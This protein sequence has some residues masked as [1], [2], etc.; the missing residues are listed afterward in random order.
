MAD[1]R[2]KRL[3]REAHAYLWAI[4]PGAASPA[5]RFVVLTPGRAGSQLVADLLNQHSRV[6]CLGELLSHMWVPTLRS[7]HI[8][9][10]GRMAMSGQ[11]VW[12]FRL[13]WL[14]LIEHQRLDAAGFLHER[15]QSGWRLIWARRR[16]L[17]HQALSYLIAEQRR[18]WYDREPVTDA[19]RRFTID[20]ARF[21]RTLARQA[22][23]RDKANAI[24]KHL[25]HEEVV[26]EDDLLLEARHQATADR[27]FA[28]LGVAP[29]AV[30]AR[31]VKTAPAELSAL[32]ANADELREALGGFDDVATF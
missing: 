26:Y 2:L 1:P 7:A 27:L 17:A 5:T 12:G 16:N 15:V 11:P 10:R 28:Y 20:P 14:H 8:Y 4:R 30:K 29:V 24:M 23:W 21:R 3:A 6:L 19:E 13:K 31:L 22:R 9:L 18:R 32:I 25:P